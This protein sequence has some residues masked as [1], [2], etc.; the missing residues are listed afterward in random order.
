MYLVKASHCSSFS[1]TEEIVASVMCEREKDGGGKEREE[2]WGRTREREERRRRRRRR[3]KPEGIEEVNV[4]F[5]FF[6][7]FF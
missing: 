1:L 5:I 6:C 7:A 2:G 4:S 3:G